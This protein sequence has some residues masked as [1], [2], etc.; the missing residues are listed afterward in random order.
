MSAAPVVPRRE[1]IKVTLASLIGTTLEFYD[2]LLYGYV[3]SVFAVLFFPSKVPLASLLAVFATF[4]VGYLF[5]PVGA[6]LFGHIGDRVGRKRALMMTL[7][8]MGL[9]SFLTA[10]LPTYAQVGILAP[11]ALVILRLIMGLALG[12]EFGG[13][14]TLTGEV[15][16]KEHRSFWVMI[17]QMSQGGG[18]L[19]A[20]GSVAIL[21]AAMA[22]WGLQLQVGDGFSASVSS[23]H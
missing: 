19:L 12:G 15:A 21:S 18:S 23:W 7:F 8:L 11:T 6:I 1:V 3:A 4:A 22:R 13:G 16:P 14:L 5:R 9:A 17:T 2:F 20:T 10:L